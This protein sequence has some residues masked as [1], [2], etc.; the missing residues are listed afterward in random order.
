MTH[1]SIINGQLVYL[2]SFEKD[3]EQVYVNIFTGA[4]EQPAYVNPMRLAQKNMYRNEIDRCKL[5]I[6]EQEAT[7]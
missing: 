7:Q 2:K 4:I 6:F 3:G 1:E 5:P